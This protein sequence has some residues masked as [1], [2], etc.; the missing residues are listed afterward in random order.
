MNVITFLA[1]NP[2]TLILGLMGISLVTIA[3]LLVRSERPVR[4]P[5]RAELYQKRNR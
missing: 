3:S 4:Q 5:I 2:F 1:N